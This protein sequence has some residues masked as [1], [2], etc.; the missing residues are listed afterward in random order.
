M[1][2]VSQTSF[3]NPAG[4]PARALTAAEVNER[5]RSLALLRKGNQGIGDSVE[6]GIKM[7]DRNNV[8]MTRGSIGL[9][10]GETNHGKSPLAATI[11]Y[12]VKERIKRDGSAGAVVIFLTEETVEK[13]QIQLWNDGRTT[14]RAVLTGAARLDLIEE[15]IAKSNADPV[16][17]IGDSAD[18][19]SA[20]L[21]DETLGM[22]TPRRIGLTMQKLIR[23][24]VKPE[25]VIVDHLHDL[26]IEKPP[27][28]E[29]EMYE[30]VGRQM[31]ALSSALKPYC[32]VLYIAQANQNLKVETTLARRLPEV[33]DMKFMSALKYKAS[34]VYSISYPKKYMNGQK[35]KIQDKDF[36][37][38][39]GLF[40]VKAAKLRDG[41]S[42][43]MVAMTALDDDGHWRG[44][45]RELA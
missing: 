45:L 38:S 24:S 10:V 26:Q 5:I 28:D 3:G 22:L 39:T 30:T 11:A 34:H 15:N 8:P 43:E 29:A 27:R 36:D 31:V 25:L 37:V 2:E 7:L 9:I 14:L 4:N 13:R 44:L 35:V 12:N 19:G 20:D 23:M 42:G 21:D 18:M 32:P 33:T 17:F 16:Y 1:S 41:N 6:T 40:V